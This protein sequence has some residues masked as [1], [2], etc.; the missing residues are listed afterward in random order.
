MVVEL[1]FLGMGP[2]GSEA[3]RA[4]PGIKSVVVF[5]GAVVVSLL[6]SGQERLEGKVRVHGSLRLSGELEGFLM[7]LVAKLLLGSFPAR[8]A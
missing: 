7:V 2:L 1:T 4:E 5:V 6:E 8:G 3:S